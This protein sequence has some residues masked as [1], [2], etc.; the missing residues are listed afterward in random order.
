MAQITHRARSL[1]AGCCKGGQML[2]RFEL[3][4]VFQTSVGENS[5]A[6]DQGEL[7]RREPRDP[8]VLPGI[9]IGGLTIETGGSFIWAKTPAAFGFLRDRSIPNG[10]TLRRFDYRYLSDHSPFQFQFNGVD[11][12]QHSISWAQELEILKRFCYYA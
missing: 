7:V 5:L 12:G 1:P 10:L 4:L 2:T 9:D 8:S 3:A 6:P 11:M